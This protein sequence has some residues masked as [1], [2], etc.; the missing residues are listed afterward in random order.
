MF[1]ASFVVN[2]TVFA[3]HG[4]QSFYYCERRAEWVE[5]STAMIG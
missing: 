1:N 5:C 3:K 4:K 2:G